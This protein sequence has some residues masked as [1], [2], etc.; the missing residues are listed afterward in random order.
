MLFMSKIKSFFKLIRWTNLLM[1]AIMM[2]LVYHCLMYPMSESG[3]VGALPSSPSFILLLISMIFIVAGGY[4]INDIFDVKIDKIN[5]PDKLIVSKVFSEDA[6]KLF[7]GILTFI[8][9]CS[10]LLSSI[11]ILDSSFYLLFATMLLLACLLYSYS[12]RYKRK[13]LVGNLIVSLSVAFAVFLPWLFEMLYLSNNTL[14]LYAV[15]ETSML[16]LPYV[17][18]YTVFAFLMTLMREIIK[19]AEDF[20]GDLVTHCRTIPIV[21]GIKKMN[22]ILGLLALLLWVILLYFQIILYHL[23]SYLALSIMYIIWIGLP[24]SIINLFNRNVKINYHRHSVS[25]KIIML[26]GILSMIFI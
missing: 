4:V 12:A 6:S 18:I 24:I 19:D 8:G 15:K 2:L 26:L 21:L 23:N 11:M 9:L 3:V 7:Y 25:L 22:L 1:I 17:L 13:L 14:I 5:K 20:Q 16:T 10:G